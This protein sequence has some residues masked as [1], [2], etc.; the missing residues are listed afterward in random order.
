MRGF[1][2]V[3][4]L[5][6]QLWPGFA[7]A[8]E[9]RFYYNNFGTP[10]LIEM[11]DA[12]MAADADLAFTL[13]HL[14]GQ[15]RN[16]LTFQVSPRLS[17]SF[18]Y[19]ALDDVLGPDGTLYDRVLDRSFSLRY[20]LSDE[21]DYLPAVA[22]G[23]DDFAGTGVYSAEYLVAT[24]TLVP[25]LS[26]TAGIGWGRL[27]GEGGFENPLGGRFADRPVRDIGQG[28]TV[29]ENNLF[30]GDAAFF[31]GLAWRMND[32]WHLAVEYSSD[33]LEYQDAGV[34]D[35][36]SPINLAVGYAPSPRLQISAQYLYGSTFGAAL[37]YALNPS[38]PPFGGGFDRGPVPV[39]PVQ[40]RSS[41]D[42]A[43]M[44][45]LA[46]EGLRL[47][48]ISWHSDRITI[49]VENLTYN[50]PA[51][52]IGR[53]ARVLTAHAPPHV[54]G[55]D[56]ALVEKGL[57]GPTVRLNRADLVAQEFA[58]DGAAQLLK[59]AQIVP[60]EVRPAPVMQPIFQWGITPYIT[61]NIFD[62]DD[63]L[64]ADFGLGLDGSWSPVAG[65]FFPGHCANDCWAIWIR[66]AGCPI[67]YCRGFVANLHYMIAKVILI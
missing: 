30:R 64:R 4:V 39:V 37:T 42:A 6:G 11:P 47:H 26:L 41:S 48:A 14:D 28:G 1:V 45:S 54:G 24:K 15:T 36:R 65:V 46:D 18:R 7:T 33:A 57:A 61:P 58:L 43:I 16:T 22:I 60:A 53:A 19:A 31:G 12:R 34:F 35:R 51:Q 8:Q 38:D 2:V 52:A 20:R 50:A 32:D 13:S 67:Q 59:T 5:L 49:E 3:A 29:R 23:V 63:P 17:A 66:R 56:I 44:R 62:P 25:A 55:F 9:P 27:A 10:G 21:T 40:R